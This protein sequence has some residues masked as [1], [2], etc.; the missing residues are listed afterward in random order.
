MS[1]IVFAGASQIA[2]VQLMGVSAP[3][4]VILMSTVLIN[5][6]MM[7]YSASLAPFLRHLGPSWK[8][9]I[10]Y[11]LTD[12]AYAFSLLRFSRDPELRRGW[13]YL[14]VALPPWIVW[15]AA[16][17]VGVFVGAQVPAAWSLEFTIPLSFLALLVPA[18]TSR[19][20][21]AAAAVGG[22]VAVLAYGLPNNLGL[23]L[24]ALAGIAAGTLLERNP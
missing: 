12:Q 8:L 14:G 17:A 11:L 3:V 4:V 20:N 24:G 2:A 18:L 15:V 23:L 19:G 9:P 21:V 1:F 16:A 7:M 22:G 10:A 6:R 5:L 13:Y